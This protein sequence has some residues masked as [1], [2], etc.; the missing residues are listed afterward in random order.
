MKYDTFPDTT[1][2]K[3]R[4]GR[5]VSVVEQDRFQLEAETQRIREETDARIV[6]NFALNTAFAIMVGPIAM[7]ATQ[8][9]ALE[10]LVTTTD[11]ADRHKTPV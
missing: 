2:K 3:D 10:A 1:T 6:G 5:L 7:P 9:I 4:Y 8:A 11:M